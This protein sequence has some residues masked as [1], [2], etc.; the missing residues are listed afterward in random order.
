[1]LISTAKTMNL[2]VCIRLH[3][4][5]F[6][7]TGCGSSTASLYEA[8]EDVFHTRSIVMGWKKEVRAYLALICLA[9]LVAGVIVAAAQYLGSETLFATG[10]VTFVSSFLVVTMM[11]LVVVLGLFLSR[12]GFDVSAVKDVRNIMA[13]FALCLLA[14]PPNEAEDRV[15]AIIELSD[16][17]KQRHGILWANVLFSWMFAQQIWNE[18]GDGI[19]KKIR[20]IVGGGKPSL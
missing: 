2:E 6:K 16:D 19:K 8:A 7:L 20:K 15:R 17:A 14:V 18:L 13:E 11:E 3:V 4:R 9:A 5:S 1:M 10:Q 12:W